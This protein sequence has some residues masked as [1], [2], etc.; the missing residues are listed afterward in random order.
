MP[1]RHPSPASTLDQPLGGRG[2][3]V[4]LTIGAHHPMAGI[5]ETLIFENGA[6]ALDGGSISLMARD[7]DGKAHEIILAQTRFLRPDNHY[8]GQ[9]PGR[10]Y[11]NGELI[12]VRSTEEGVLLGHLRQPRIECPVADTEK[13]RTNQYEEERNPDVGNYLDAVAHGP[14]AA[15]A[16]IVQSILEFV[17][18]DKYLEMAEQ[19]KQEP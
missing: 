9:I 3:S 5:P 1:G 12:G 11:L 16:H 6:F 2:S 14:A 8:I 10:L 4:N 17:E 13:P 18:S 19:T 15:V 7:G